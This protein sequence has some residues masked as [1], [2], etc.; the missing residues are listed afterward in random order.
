MVSRVEGH[1]VRGL[2]QQGRGSMVTRVEGRGLLQ[3]G[4]GSMVE[5]VRPGSRVDV[6]LHHRGGDTIIYRTNVMSYIIID[7]DQRYIFRRL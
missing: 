1:Q 4:R 5:V 7:T 6:I 3:Q 2:L